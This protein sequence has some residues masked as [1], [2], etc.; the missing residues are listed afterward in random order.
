ML[1]AMAFSKIEGFDVTPRRPSSSISRLNSPL[2]N[3]LR[4]R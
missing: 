2:V 3:K 4:R 1:P